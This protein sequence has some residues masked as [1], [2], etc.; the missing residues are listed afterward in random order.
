MP[1]NGEDGTASWSDAWP[2]DADRRIKKS[3]PSVLEHPQ[4]FTGL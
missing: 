3:N 1:I 4:E 2:S